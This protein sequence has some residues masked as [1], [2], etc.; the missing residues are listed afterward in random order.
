MTP[1]LKNVL[2][3]CAIFLIA[4]CSTGCKN[5]KWEAKPWLG[6]SVHQQLVNP[7]NEKIKCDQPA[8]DTMT[9][10][11]PENIAELKSAIDRVKMSKKDR[12]KLN[13]ALEGAFP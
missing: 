9:C 3:A 11:D 2:S 5:F 8:F 7:E 4:S 10:F 6:D 13:K 1:T 12:V